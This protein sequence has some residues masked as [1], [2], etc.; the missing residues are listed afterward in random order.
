MIPL[1][2]AITISKIMFNAFTI[3][4]VHNESRQAFRVFLVI[5]II[6][7]VLSLFTLNPIV[8][9]IEIGECLLYVMFYVKLKE[10]KKMVAQQQ[11]NN[12]ELNDLVQI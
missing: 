6:G 12:Q 7:T 11:R 2:L 3:W 4:A 1:V 10:K 5:D 8:I 9:L